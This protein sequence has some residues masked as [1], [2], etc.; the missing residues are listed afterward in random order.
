MK[1]QVCNG[2]I[3]KERFS[4]Y[5]LKRL[6]RD[7]EKFEL[8]N[9]LVNSCACMGHCKEGPNV[10]FD[11]HTEHHMDP[12]KASKMMMDKIN[13]KKG[14]KSSNEKKHKESDNG[15]ATHSFTFN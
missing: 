10:M 3:C 7:K 4:E 6:E 14:H 13:Q 2:K 8:D 9:V 1:I 12:S 11:K 15:E 5:I